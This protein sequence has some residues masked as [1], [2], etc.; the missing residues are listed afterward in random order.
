MPKIIAILDA[1]GEV[2]TLVHG[3]SQEAIQKII[4]DGRIA[5]D[6][7]NLPQ[8]KVEAYRNRINNATENVEVIDENSL[9]IN[10]LVKRI[11]L[12]ET[13][14]KALENKINR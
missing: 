10:V 14:I 6:S 2:E 8:E 12:L 4:G 5:V 1:T 13:K 9:D 7:D 3:D 11:K